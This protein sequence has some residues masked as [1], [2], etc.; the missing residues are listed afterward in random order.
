MRPWRLLAAVLPGGL[1]LAF[2]SGLI[3]LLAS[4]LTGGG[5]EYAAFF[6][7]PDYVRLLLRTWWLAAATS[8][9][10]VSSAAGRS[11]DV[12]SLSSPSGRL[13]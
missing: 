8:A 7:R 10:I 3:G 5:A 13:T 12:R 9:I 1:L 4:S 6:A 11:S 2:V